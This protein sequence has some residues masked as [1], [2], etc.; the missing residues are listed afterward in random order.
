MMG[1]SLDIGFPSPLSMILS[2]FILSLLPCPV[3]VPYL[4]SLLVFTLTL[5]ISKCSRLHWNGM[6]TSYPP[7]TTPNMLNESVPKLIDCTLV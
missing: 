2:L 4:P 1:F 7:Q 3:P 6:L 5:V